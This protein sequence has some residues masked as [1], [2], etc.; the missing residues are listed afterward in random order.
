[1]AT[2]SSSGRR[3]A[4]RAA[5]DATLLDAAVRADPD[6]AGDA[7]ARG[8]DANAADDATGHTAVTCAI[9]GDSWEDVDVTDASFALP[10]RL[11]VLR[12]LIGSDTTS[13][14]ALNAPVR[15]VTPLGLAAWLNIPD[16]I[17]VLLEESRGL[18]AVD[19]TDALGVTP[20]MYTARDGAVEAASLLLLK[21]ARP[22]VRDTHHRTAIQHAL[23]HPQMLHLCES[24]LRKQRARDFL[25][26]NRRHLCD[27]PHVYRSQVDSWQSSSLK[28]KAWFSPSEATL[29]KAT[30]SLIRAVCTGDVLS[31]HQH[32]FLNLHRTPV[33]VNRLDS[34]GWSPLHYCVCAEN[35]SLEVLDALFLAGA[36]T[37]LYTSSRHGTSLHC[38]ARDASHPPNDDQVPH[39]HAFVRHLVVDLR[40]PLSA[41]DENGETCIHVAAEHGQSVE[42]LLALLSCDFR[43]VVREMVNSR[44]LTAFEVARPEF[45][46]AFGVDA[47]PRRSSSVAS[48]RTVRPST[49]SVSSTSSYASFL[50]VTAPA[51]PHPPPDVIFRPETPLPEAEASLLP[52]RI[53]DNLAAVGHD[54]NA[55]DAYEMDALRAVLDETVHLGELWVHSMHARI[56]DA[57]QDLRDARS[58]FRQVDLLLQDATHA[59]EEVFGAQFTEARDSIER[60][61]R[62]TT[63]SGDSEA[64]AVSGRASS[65]IGRKW[66]SMSDLRASSESSSSGGRELPEIHVVPYLHTKPIV[67]EDEPPSSPEKSSF[68][69][70]LLSPSTRDLA[71]KGSKTDLSVAPSRT[72][73]PFP[74]KKDASA[75]GTSRLKAWFRKKLRFE[76]P[77][78]V[79]EVKDVGYQTDAARSNI[80]SPNSPSRENSASLELLSVSRSIVRTAN[81]DLSCIEGCMDNADHYLSLASRMLL[82]AERRLRMIVLN[83]KAALESARLAQL[84]DDLDDP[85]MS[86]IAST[87]RSAAISQEAVPFPLARVH[88]R[89]GSGSEYSLASGSGSSSTSPMSSVISL[90]S[91][92]IESEDDDTRVLRRLLTRKVDARTDGAGEEIDRA[93]TWLRIVQDTVRAL[94]RRTRAPLGAAPTPA[95]VAVPTPTGSTPTAMIPHENRL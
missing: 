41:Q 15:G 40:A 85:F 81:R 5:L 13:L 21:G 49:C 29:A 26:G 32:L 54:W 19:G 52:H 76:I 71:R 63:D 68:L 4:A 65:Q 91:T 31:L 67:E 77:E 79:V 84:Q 74:G 1:M 90:S 44:G 64:T 82:Q 39:L 72:S 12:A 30:S 73:S 34:Q 60:T 92:L 28:W 22:D 87:V 42:V 88:G 70:A 11:E 8:A 33:L 24:A 47:E 10:R 62:R 23:R 78:G 80:S 25:N 75:S 95:S 45:R 55:S 7:L 43:G 53:L 27:I 2:S 48:F 93:L 9:A 83:R 35:L 59:L 20:L 61:R 58:R 51:R 86:A 66:R 18:V 50:P 37:S 6:A 17:R 57:A 89:N 46:T 38:L 69:N 16:A 3:R 36:D 94:R 56:R 14:Y